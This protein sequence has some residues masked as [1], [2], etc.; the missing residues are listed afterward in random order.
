[1]SAA[2]VALWGLAGLLGALA[3]ARPGDLHVR[4]LKIALDQ[5]VQVFP[6]LV[7]ALV[8]AGFVSQIVPNEL[9]AGWLG[10]GSGIWG[11]LIASA[12]GGIVPGGPVVVY[13]IAVVLLESGVGTPQLVA[14][15]TGWSVFAMHRVIVF[16]VPL[17]GWRF[18]VLRFLATLPLPVAAGFSAGIVLAIFSA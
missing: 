11:I 1:M 4:G 9:V 13:P 2:L 12:A 18:S 8:T 16:E 3:Y 17:I 5:V 15:L 6:M 10:A 14:F 7:L